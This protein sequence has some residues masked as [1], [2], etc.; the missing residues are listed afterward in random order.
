[1]GFTLGQKLIKSHL[2]SGDM[3]PG[4]EVGI[5]IDQTLTRMPPARWPIW[6]LKRWA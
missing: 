1:M 3:T 6:N 4:S 2:V 5:R